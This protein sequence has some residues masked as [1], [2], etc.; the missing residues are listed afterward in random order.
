MHDVGVHLVERF[1]VATETRAVSERSSSVDLPWVMRSLPQS[2][3]LR[4]GKDMD[5]VATVCLFGRE[6]A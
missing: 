1:K 4:G 2:R 5:F 3:Q 6:L